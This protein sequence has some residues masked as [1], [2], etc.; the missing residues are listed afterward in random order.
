MD[1]VENG[2]DVTEPHGPAAPKKQRKMETIKIHHRNV[3]ASCWLV[4]GQKNMDPWGW[5][6][7]EGDT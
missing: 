2:V 4:S 3:L 1:A 5:G 7:G 6:R